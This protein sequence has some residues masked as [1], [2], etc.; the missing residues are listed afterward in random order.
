LNHH[1][2]VIY[3]QHCYFITL[4]IIIFTLHVRQH[5]HHNTFSISISISFHIITC[6]TF[7]TYTFISFL[8]QRCRSPMAFLVIILL[9]T[10]FI[11]FHFIVPKGT[12]PSGL[13]HLNA[14]WGA[15][16]W[17]FTSHYQRDAAQWSFTLPC[18]SKRSQ[19]VF[20]FA[21]PKGTQPSGLFF[22]LLCQRGCG[23]VVFQFYSFSFISQSPFNTHSL[24]TT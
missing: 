3:T 18:L 13:S 6:Y 19:V 8:C 4:H 16:Q 2:H 7:S 15:S 24:L 5:I 12:Q 17:S 1:K 10:F 22:R 9:Y 14:K 20:Q 23:L 11:H 21:L